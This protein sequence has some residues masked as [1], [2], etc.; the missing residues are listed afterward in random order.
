[1]ESPA[2]EK[3]AHALA[4]ARNNNWP[5]ARA[6]FE[7]IVSLYP[8]DEEAWFLLGAVYATL[9]LPEESIR[10]YKQAI[11]IRP[12]YAEA[13]NNL[14]TV[15]EV[16]QQFDSALSSYQHALELNPEN[17]AAH[18]NLGNI[19]KKKGRLEEAVT[20]YRKALYLD[21]ANTQIYL[22][23]A[24]ALK[25]LG[26]TT[27]AIS[28]LKKALAIN[29]QYA[30]A[31]NLMGNCLQ[32]EGR[33]TDAINYYS[34]ALQEN[35]DNAVTFNNI[36]S[37]LMA[38]GSIVDAESYYKKA[39]TLRPEWAAAH[40]NLLLLMN[41]SNAD[42]DSILSAHKEWAQKHCA[43]EVFSVPRKNP[44]K[45]RRIRVG[46]M[47]PDFRAHSVS[48]FV[49]AILERHNRAGFE[50]VCYSNVASPDSVTRHFMSVSD[51]WRNIFG[52][53][54]ASVVDLIRRDRI[55]ILVDLSG[56]TAN[57]RLPVFC[58][59]PAPVQVTY[60]GYP[61]TTGIEAIDY[62]LTDEYADPAGSSDAFYTETL[63][64]LPHGFLCYSPPSNV[65]CIVPPPSQ[66]RN[67]ISF[68]CFN[69]LSK[70]TP[71]VVAVWCELL[72]KLPASKII[73]KNGSMTDLPTC[74][75]YK[76]YFSDHGIKEERVTFIGRTSSLTTHLAKYGQVDIALDT[77][78][79]NGTTT[80]CE[81]L[82]MGV[83]VVTLTGKLHAG[84]VGMSLMKQ[85]GLDSLVADTVS[86]YVNIALSL[87]NEESY[88]VNLRHSLRE[89]LSGSAL[90]NA[91]QF[92]QELEDAYK[93]ML[94][95]DEWC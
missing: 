52:M 46:Y 49:Q 87:A 45:G 58:V 23:Y 9:E 50:I 5:E 2:A 27:Q 36:G 33:L 17:V 12:G 31:L 28:L 61:N 55:D 85:V 34:K 53:D 66:S 65:P 56:H 94:G 88:L 75:R 4:C 78:P 30:P 3:K 69:N 89:T 13:F 32:T 80:T 14:G 86:S 93:R 54:D 26:D 95:W 20:Y 11:S 67:Y 19:L 35:N 62:R 70:I 29:P 90:C 71:E 74:E 73:I 16:N 84:R 18:Y 6:L 79:Y 68:G 59:K 25:Q 64:R 76:K 39:L 81:A 10:S 8:R 42:G 63:V 51:H 83:P 40:S 72:N 24:I 21:D 48:Y 60:L 41:Y 22:D 15:Y 44:G 57:N 38:M 77:F 82:W 1:M 91:G 92:V 43:R 7:E 37:A 47:S